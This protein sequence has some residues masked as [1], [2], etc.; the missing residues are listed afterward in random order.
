VIAYGRQPMR[1]AAV[2]P[3]QPTFNNLI[4]GSLALWDYHRGD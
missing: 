4:G 3:P 1:I 2:V